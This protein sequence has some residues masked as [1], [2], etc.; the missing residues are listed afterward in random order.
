MNAS[1]SLAPHQRKELAALL[2]EKE[3]RSAVSSTVV[4][5]VC[6][7]KGLTHAIK[8]VGDKWERTTQEPQV[9]LPAKMER[10]LTSDKRFIVVIG[11]RGSGKSVS[12]ADICLIDAHDTGAK[13]YCLREYQSSIRNSV[14]SLLREEIE[15]LEFKGFDVMHNSIAFK[16]NDSFEFAGL[17]RNVDSIKSAYGFKRFWG[18]E[19]QSLSAD[20]LRALTPTARAKPN[21]GLPAQFKDSSLPGDLEDAA[22]TVSMIFV[23]NPFSSEDPFSKRFITPYLADLERDG[24]YEDELHLILMM[25]YTDNPWFMESGLEDER[26][27]D[28][29][30]LPRALYDHIWLG[31]FNDSVESSLVMAEWFDACID[32]HKKLGFEGKGVKVA[33]HDPS[34]TGPDPKGYAMRHGSIILD[35]QEKEDGSVNE[36][37]HW[38]ARIAISQGVDAFSWDGTGMGAALAEQMSMDFKGKPTQLSAFISAESPDFPDNIYK[39]ALEAPVGMQRTNSQVF[40]N[41]RAQYAFALRDR[42]YRTYRAVVHHE[43]ADPD[44][45]ISFSSSMPL[46]SKLRAETCRVPRKPNSNGLNELYTKQEMKTKFK[47]ASPNLF[48]AVV[49]TMRHIPHYRPQYQMPDPIR[50]IG[51]RSH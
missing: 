3:R 6:P 7:E 27:W 39:A 19:S 40:K 21:K 46:L 16:D 20:S 38:A 4:G 13:T 8:R 37:G 17:A 31:K 32:A 22:S 34:D 23:A 29:E 28:Y 30:H 5:L 2:I 12:V 48:D 44:T 35:I 10:V 11:G 43:Y 45:L 51:Y 26:K 15:R 33:S 50:P 14:Y 1:L 25:N 36:G 47:M 49:M 9:Y 41:K 42:I 24:Y 18:E